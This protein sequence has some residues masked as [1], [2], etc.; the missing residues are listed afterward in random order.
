MTEYIKVLSVMDSDRLKGIRIGDK[1][2]VDRS[3]TIGCFVKLDNGKE[4]ILTREQYKF[5]DKREFYEHD[6]KH[7]IEITKELTSDTLDGVLKGN[8][9]EV[10][11]FDRDGDPRIDIVSS[12]NYPILPHQYKF[13]TKSEYMCSA[14][15]NRTESEEL[16][17]ETVYFRLT[18]TIMNDSDHGLKAGESYK[19]YRYKGDLYVDLP[20]KR[21][22]HIVK[23]QY[24]EITEEEFEMT[25]E[26]EYGYMDCVDNA[27][28]SFWTQGKLY[29]ISKKTNEHGETYYAFYDDEGEDRTGCNIDELV[30]SYCEDPNTMTNG[31]LNFKYIA[32]KGK[33][34]VDTK[35]EI[36]AELKDKVDQLTSHGE[37]LFKKRDRINQQAIDCNNKARQIEKAI[38]LIEKLEK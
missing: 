20:E 10:A 32:P 23:S 4:L 28:L 36:L 27:G 13:I 18:R 6:G 26:S 8:V 21:G 22:I 3:Y 11:R 35:A 30:D 37:N 5:I 17:Q 14:G 24:E 12:S 16:K 1:L 2:K 31:C 33:E 19:G 38:E 29:P 25:K 34:L 9:Y 7:Y 15:F